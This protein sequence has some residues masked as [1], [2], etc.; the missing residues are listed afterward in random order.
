MK[1]I[2]TMQDISCVGKC[3]LTV[4]LPI[5]SAMGIE[6]AVIP[7]AVLSTH[8]GFSQ[9]TFRD[10]TDDIPGIIDHW[11]KEGFTFDAV[12]SGYLGSIRQIELVSGLFDTFR[13]AIRLV[14]PA[15]ADNG[16]LYS[17]FNDEFV[18]FMAKL[19]ATADYIV[20]NLT[21]ACL[22]TGKDYKSDPDVGF[23]HEIMRELGSRGTK[24]VIM[25]GMSDGDRLGAI[26][27]NT[28]KDSFDTYYNERIGCSFHG[29]GDIF[30]SCMLGAL[31]LGKSCNSAM[32]LA[33]DYTLECIRKTI[34][35]PTHNMYG[36]NFEQALPFL[37]T[38]LS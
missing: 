36:V 29:T 17:G 21:E 12:Y 26:S 38:R 6:T 11:K 18:S 2:I 35:E 20:P 28:E 34:A 13:P 33:V 23:I 7:T 19:C 10:L 32:S 24:N 37:I 31:T 5:I 25:T 1:R 8:T 22:L 9:F 27:Y 14:D 4:A 15:M 30:A 3:S 16:Q